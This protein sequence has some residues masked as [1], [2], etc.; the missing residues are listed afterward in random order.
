MQLK[1][2]TL[3]G[4][5][6]VVTLLALIFPTKGVNPFSPKITL[7]AYFPEVSGLRSSSPVWFS[8]MEVG[9]VT[10]VDFVPGSNP[11]RLKVVLKVERKIQQYLK[12]DSRAVIKG[13]GLLGDMYIDLTPGSPEAK[14]IEDGKEIAGVPPARTDED[15]NKMLASAGQL[16]DNLKLVSA[17]L[18]EGQG[19]LGQLLKDPS[20]YAELRESVRGLKT[21]VAS[22][23]EDDGT[24]QRLLKDPVLYQELVATIQDAHA[25]VGDLKQAEEK[26]LSPETRTTLDQTVKTAS[27]VIQRVGEIQ[28][29]LDRIRFELSF[30]LDRQSAD[31]SAGHAEL[32]IWPSRQRYYQVGIRKA[33]RLYGN[34]EEETTFQAQLAWQLF[35]SPFY[36]RGG[37]IKSDY[38]VAGMDLRLWEDDFKVLL[39][40]YRVEFTPLQLDLSAGMKVLEPIELS[41]GV[42]DILRTPFY[43]AGLVIHYR[44]QDLLDVLLKTQF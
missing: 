42:E 32:E 35:N 15:V 37:L 21:M 13:M 4:V 1:V 6:L 17:D 44:D 12:T 31:V 40:A 39:D 8:G 7:I 22:L 26:V 14:G 41:A 36:I 33:S 9:A 28:E 10:Y 30:G 43:K 16:L 3:L 27:R 34:E 25:V 19:T 38:F 23:N 20:L 11:P 5:A 2:G 24:V 29:K 18:A